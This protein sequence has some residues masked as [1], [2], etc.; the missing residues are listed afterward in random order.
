MFRTGPVRYL[1]L[2][3]QAGSRC[4]WG[5]PLF[6]RV[7]RTLPFPSGTARGRRLPVRD[8]PPILFCLDKREPSR[9]ASLAPSGQFTFCTAAGGRENCWEEQEDPFPGPP[10]RECGGMRIGAARGDGPVDLA[11]GPSHK[12]LRPRIPWCGGWAGCLSDLLA[13]LSPRVPRRTGTRGGH[14]EEEKRSGRFRARSCGSVWADQPFTMEAIS[15]A[16]FSCFFSMPSPFSKRM[17]FLKAT[18]PPRALA[19]EAIY[20]STVMELSFTNSCCSRQFSA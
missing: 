17:A 14:R 20:F 1:P 8:P 16:K 6:G 2:L 11:P 7:V 5:F 4:Q 18:L 9:V 15:S 13:L 12:E 3:Y 19:A 10:V